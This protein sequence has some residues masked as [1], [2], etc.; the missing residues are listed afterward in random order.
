MS[1]K[2]PKISIIMCTYNRAQFLSRSIESILSQTF[3]D[4]EFIVVINGS[5]DSSEII[6]NKYAEQDSRI[7]LIPITENRGAPV[8]RNKGL[9][10]A[11][12]EFI[13]IVDDDDCCEPQ[14]LEFLWGLATKYNAD[15]AMCGS[16]NDFSSRK[17]PYFIF[18]D[19]LI[20]DK[21]QGL[22][23]LLKR[24][25]YNVAPPTKLF[26]KTLFDGIHF[27]E[28]VIVDDIH[29]IYKIFAKANIVVVQGKPLYSFTKHGSNMTSFIQTDVLSPRI[30]NEYL[31]AFRQR[32]EYLCKNVPGI[33]SRVRYSEWSYMISMCQKIKQ[34]NNT[35]CS[36]TYEFMVKTLH[37]N[38]SELI[39]NP[40]ITEMEKTQ[41]KGM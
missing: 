4:F 33:T 41:L 22:D 19:L 24:E 36:E 8:G 11:S 30:L 21:V 34:Y 2:M 40:F 35:D 5:T 9:E 10:V 37:E 1:L 29:I 18:D 20:L 27:K 26:R 25:K 38:Y 39:E 3:T 6:C 17:E 16:W 14:M 15:I 7:R 31:S 12:C 23:E 28:N 13:T 32:T